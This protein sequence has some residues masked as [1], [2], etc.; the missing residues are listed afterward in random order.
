M[1]WAE[2]TRR[3]PDRRAVFDDARGWLSAG[4]LDEETRHTAYGFAA[5]GLRPGD[6]ILMSAKASVALATAHV[7]ALRLGLVVVPMN[8][9][10]I[11]REIAH[12]VADAAPR[13]AITD[14]AGRLG[15]VAAASG[16]PL[17]LR[18][19]IEAGALTLEVD[20]ADSSPEPSLEPLLDQ[21]APADPALVVYTSGTTG[22][23]KGAVLTHGNLLASI[24]ALRLAWRWTADDL[25][26]L[27]L[28]L[29][30]VHGLGIG[31]HGAL[32][33]GSPVV[34]GAPTQP[35]ALAGALS[36]HDATMLFAVPTIYARLVAAGEASSLG[37]LRLAVSGSAPLPAE[38][39]D[40]IRVA[41][42][43]RVLERY[44]MTETLMIASNPY[45]G[46]RRPGT[47]GFP[48]P[49]V[50]VRLAAEGP[51]EILVRGPNVFSGYLGLPEATASAFEGGWFHTG[52][53]GSF[54]SDGYLRIVGRQSELVIS[55]GYNVYP[56]EVEDVL[57]SHPAVA[58]AAVVGRPH[59]D[60]G[61][62]VVAFAELR[63]GAVA[64]EE[65]LLEHAAGQLAAFKRPK[66][67]TIVEELPRNALG[68]VR[69]GE[70][71]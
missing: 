35:D 21:A 38:L 19:M 71:A 70:L 32:A 37:A 25:L 63:P 30:H 62:E 34:L 41:S 17:A 67:I 44:G 65:E 10:Y 24:Q 23:P 61:E 53:V 4:E 13:A 42:G 57:R 47:V 18:G 31:L 8:T 43:Q 14:D 16:A 69:K 2:R 60:W 40:A 46:E 59:P 52:D 29:F 33:T 51:A 56:R 5:A 68:K 15:S 45:E 1:L 54:D 3:G 48:L 49:G 12:L 20:D 50:E 22:K 26:V 9:G 55:G 36:H 11:A 28:P 6:R 66:S 58:D 39:H 7:A 27:P 64:T